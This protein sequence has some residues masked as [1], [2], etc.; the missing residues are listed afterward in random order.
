MK[1]INKKNLFFLV[2]K[3]SYK[4]SEH[5]IKSFEYAFDGIIYCFRAS[6]NFRIHL[7]F[8]FL[9]FLFAYL[10]KINQVEF[11]ILIA[12]VTSVLVL[13]ILNTSIESLVDLVT[14]RKFRKLA[15]IAKDCAAASVLLTSIN[16]LFVA[17]YIF[18]PKIKLLINL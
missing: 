3:D 2:R 10:L 14:E 4:K 16:S 5:L 15:K 13:E 18:F 17:V 12:T 9:V 11:L 8:T 6:L 1:S 7:F